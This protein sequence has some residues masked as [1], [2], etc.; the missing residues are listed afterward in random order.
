MFGKAGT[1]DFVGIRKRDGKFIAWEAKAPGKKSRTT[2][3]QKTFLEAVRMWNGIAVVADC[4]ED[5]EEAIK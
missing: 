4:V 3:K 5:L 2:E 1:S